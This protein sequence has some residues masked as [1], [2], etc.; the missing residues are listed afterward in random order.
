MP[1]SQEFSEE[2]DFES[3]E[4][5]PDGACVGL[6]GEDGNCRLCGYGRQE[7]ESLSDESSSSQP[8]PRQRVGEE[9]IANPSDFE[10]R[11]LCPDGACTGLLDHEGRCKV[12]GAVQVV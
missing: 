10:D 11:R 4:L 6:L 1:A 5:C 7:T 2:L 12:C 3:R 9:M 8:G